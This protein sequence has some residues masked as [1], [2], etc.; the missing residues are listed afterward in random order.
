MVVKGS[1]GPR[2]GIGIKCG[3]LIVGGDAGYMTGFMMQK[4]RI[5]ICGNAHKALGDSIHAGTIYVG[6]GI[7]TAVLIALNCH[8]PIHLEDYEKLGTTPNGCNHCQTGMCP[9]G[10]TTQVPELVARLDPDEAADRVV[11]YLNAMTMEL[12]L[13]ARACG[14]SRVHDLDPDDLRALTHD[15]SM[16]TGVPMVG[17]AG[18][19]PSWIRS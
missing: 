1:V 5:V 18:R 19:K 9:V 15:A 4:G 2:S 17:L 14:K 3:Q 6:G 13:F 12:Q 7:G 8:R 10:I 16:M 11:N